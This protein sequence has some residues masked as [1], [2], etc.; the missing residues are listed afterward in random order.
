MADSISFLR[1]LE[2]WALHESA[3]PL[4][5][6]S[7]LL[8]VEPLECDNA[9]YEST[10]T[11][12][13]MSEERMIV[14]FVPFGYDVD[15][16]LVRFHETADYVDVFVIYEMPYTLL[17]VPKSLLFDEIC[18]QPRFKA[19][20][21]KIIYLHPDVAGM[22]K[23]LHTTRAAIDR[24]LDAN[25]R[26]HR[27]RVQRG[28]EKGDE[29]KVGGEAPG[30]VRLEPDMYAINFFFDR[31]MVR[32]FNEIGRIGSTSGER[33]TRR[34]RLNQSLK[35]KLQEQHE[36][37]RSVYAIQ[38]DGDELVEGDV[39]RHLRHCELRADVSRIYTPCFSFKGN[40]HWLQTTRDMRSF[41]FGQDTSA[42]MLSKLGGFLKKKLEHVF[43]KGLEPE[44]NKYLWK[45]GPYLWPLSV[46]VKSEHLMRRNFSEDVFFEHHMGYGAAT[47][48]S[49]VN[50]PVEHW[51]RT[52]GTVEMVHACADIVPAVVR[53]AAARGRVTSKLL[54]DHAVF[55][56]CHSSN[57]SV[58]TDSLSHEARQVVLKSVP[59]VV[60]NNPSYFPF[61]LP[62]S[63]LKGTG[64]YEQ[65][66]H[67]EWADRCTEY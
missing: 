28:K 35:E 23:V 46:V 64:L 57:P 58:H 61:M 37:G 41:G 59:W 33:D 54:F 50:D 67:R 53:K 40:Y 5:A 2:P 13:I 17:G 51:L 24:V 38:N 21:D 19:F 29:G 20:A 49:A 66:L 32:Q 14:D 3:V 39:L 60:R 6:K 55:P 10:L 62:V 25:I 8:E 18:K 45:L 52:C 56:W 9:L 11:G 43:G 26:G 30:Q 7:S 63:G 1:L 4:R 16:L 15:K 44:L 65:V 48:M 34:S 27:N 12:R 22:Q 31:D 42:G 47:H 36:N